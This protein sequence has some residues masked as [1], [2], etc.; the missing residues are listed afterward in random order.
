M[1][2]FGILKFKYI[3][4]SILGSIL[5]TMYDFWEVLFLVPTTLDSLK[6][7]PKMQGGPHICA[8]KVAGHIPARI[9]V[10]SSWDVETIFFINF[11]R[12]TKLVQ[13]QL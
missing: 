6:S 7:G 12:S 13:E 11:E 8:Y 1:K 5:A 9:S 3:F 4:W 10:V 2:T